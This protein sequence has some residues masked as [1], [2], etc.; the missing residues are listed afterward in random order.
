MK[1][2]KNTN[3]DKKT[4][5]SIEKEAEPSVEKPSDTQKN[6]DEIESMAEMTQQD[7]KHWSHLQTKTDLAA[8]KILTESITS[9]N[10][11][12]ALATELA[13]EQPAPEPE[14]TKLGPSISG[15]IEA[16]ITQ[17]GDEEMSYK[18]TMYNLHKEVYEQVW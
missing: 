16:F 13:T 10:F 8:E 7:N 12:N 5:T 15:A 1:K 3:E 14:P 4:E 17:K 18:Q 9:G 6:D 2:N 11:D